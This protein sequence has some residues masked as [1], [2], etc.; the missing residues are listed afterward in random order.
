M[1]LGRGPEALRQ[2]DEAL[3]LEPNNQP[4]LEPQRKIR[5]M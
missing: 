4:V 3:K 5:S 2:L 1:N